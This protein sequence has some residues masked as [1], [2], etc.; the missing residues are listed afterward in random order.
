[1]LLDGTV[2]R[3]ESGNYSVR[4]RGGTQVYV[5]RLRGNLKKDLEYSTSGSRPRRVMRTRKRCTTD[6]VAVG[7]TVTFDPNTKTIER[8]AARRSELAR[9]SPSGHEQHVL[10]A[11]LDNVFVTC[12]AANPQPDFWLLD[13]FLVASEA[14]DLVAQII[15]NK[16]D[17]AVDA[18]ETRRE[19]EV[20]ERVG[21]RVHFVSAKAGEGIDG[22]TRELM[23]RISAFAG[24][25]GVGKSSL[26]NTI[27]PGLKL[28]TGVVGEITHKGRHTTTTA[29]LIPI[30]FDADT[31]VADTPGLRQM[32]FWEVDK[33]EIEYCF[34]EF[35]LLIGQCQFGN[36][37]HQTEPGCGVRDA[38]RQGAIN[39]RRYESYVQIVNGV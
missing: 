33:A 9:T 29:E 35:D 5:V 4:V 28:K 27:Q 24:P 15:V 17:L 39:Q 31:W 36:C 25:S 8:V 20:Y 23:G 14:A 34:P 11:N 10:V 19:F 22:L 3:G 2:F 18:D 30:A 37:T 13:R 1:M 32:H 21:Y 12:S 26:L 38:V 7:D 16:M 6:P